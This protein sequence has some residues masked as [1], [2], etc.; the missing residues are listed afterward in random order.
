MLHPEQT[1]LLFG[2]SPDPNMPAWESKHPQCSRRIHVSMPT[3][4]TSSTEAIVFVLARLRG[5]FDLSGAAFEHLGIPIQL[6]RRDLAQVGHKLG[7]P[8]FDR[9]NRVLEP[10]LRAAHLDGGEAAI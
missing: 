7:H 9:N 8:V 2:C 3:K 6:A 4:S 5:L 1:E 10:L